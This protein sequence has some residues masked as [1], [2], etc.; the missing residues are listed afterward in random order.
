MKKTIGGLSV[1]L[2][3]NNKHKAIIFIHGFPYDHSMWQAQID[4]FSEAYYC[5]AY[6]VR[7]LGNSSVGDGQ[8]TMESFVDDLERIIDEL[9]LETPIICGFS[10]GGYITLRALERMEAKFSAVILCDTAS[11][12]DNNEGKINRSEIIQRINARGFPSFAKNFIA[13]C[14]GDVYKKAHKEEVAK[15]IAKSIKYNSIGVKGCIL[16][17][18]S[19]NDTTAYLSSINIPTLVLCGEN[20]TITPPDTMRAMAEKIKGATFV[21]LKDSAHMSVVENS[22]DANEAIKAFLAKL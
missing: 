22:T 14:Y 12:A 20:D 1:L 16:A 18:I 7:G 13:R 15:R 8:F 3:G 9:Q 4:A 19:R 5:I 21:L 11:H 6:D 2:E 17:M 10:M